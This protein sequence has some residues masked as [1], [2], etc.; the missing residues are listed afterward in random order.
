MLVSETTH[1]TIYA[2]YSILRGLTAMMLFTFP[3]GLSS[4]V[5]VRKICEKLCKIVLQQ[6]PISS[7]YGIGI[8]HGLSNYG[9]L[10]FHDQRLVVRQPNLLRGPAVKPTGSVF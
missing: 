9:C 3:G 7:C 4:C 6:R 2:N 1:R 5:N 8:S 10:T